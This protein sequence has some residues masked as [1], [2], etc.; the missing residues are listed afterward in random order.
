MRLLLKDIRAVNAAV[1]KK[2]VIITSLNPILDKILRF[3]SN[4]EAIMV[5]ATEIVLK[6]PSWNPSQANFCCTNRCINT[7][8]KGY[9]FSRDIK[10]VVITN[11]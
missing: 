4:N 10:I 7:I 6:R 3:V 2:P 5:P 9:L 8:I 11:I 1:I